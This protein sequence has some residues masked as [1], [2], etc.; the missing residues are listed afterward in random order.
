MKATI[1]LR[2]LLAALTLGVAGGALAQANLEINTPAIASL[3]ASMQQRHA[4]LAGFYA[5]G[6][7]GLTRDGNIALRDANAVPLAQRQQVNSLVAA[8]NQ[9]RAALYR[10]IARANGKPEWE[11]DIRATFA[12]RWIQKA[13]PGWYYQNASGAWTRK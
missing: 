5:S 11:S 13:Q 8:E 10:E 3:Q 1:W 6:A 9:D 4:Q 2:I 7:V 12:Q